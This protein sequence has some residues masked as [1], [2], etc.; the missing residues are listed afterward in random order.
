MR[1]ARVVGDGISA[2]ACAAALASNGWHVQMP[3]TDGNCASVPPVLVIN[4]VTMDVLRALLG[5]AAFP[6][7]AWR[8][9]RRQVIWGGDQRVVDETAWSVCGEEFTQCWGESVRRTFGIDD[10]TAGET[11]WEFVA[12]RPAEVS[13]FGQRHAVTTTVSM[14]RSACRSTSVVES[15]GDGWLFFAPV[16]DGTGLLQG[17]LPSRPELPDRALRRMLD[18][19]HWVRGL[20]RKP[21]RANDR[22][23]LFAAAPYLNSGLAGRGR[24]L[25]GSAAMAVDPV[26]GDGVGY[27]VRSAIL[28]AGLAQAVEHGKDFEICASHFRARLAKAMRAHLSACVKYY[29]QAGFSPAWKTEINR[30]T[31]TTDRLAPEAKCSLV[32][33]ADRRVSVSPAHGQTGHRSYDMHR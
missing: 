17:M 8:L 7:T 29:G 3:R 11:C 31:A 4:D 30:C 26:C 27:G 2:W 24:L 25:L 16:S 20:V 33:R 12:S 1:R 19:S 14:S 10:V 21:W 23:R 18:Q 22:I 28:A 5:S 6:A 32:L 13:R 9:V 15:V